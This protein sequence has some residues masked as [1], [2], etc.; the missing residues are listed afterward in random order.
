MTLIRAGVAA[1]IAAAVSVSEVTI[2][3]AEEA[4][5]M[6]GKQKYLTSA[7][8]GERLLPLNRNEVN[9]AAQP[10]ACS[11]DANKPSGILFASIDEAA[12]GADKCAMTITKYNGNGFEVYDQNWNYLYS[13]YTIRIPK[14]EDTD[15][16]EVL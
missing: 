15:Q 2:H 16:F 3:S 4:V 6:T 11:S 12:S 5:P 8:N 1:M 13:G 7:G 9:E 10:P 14:I